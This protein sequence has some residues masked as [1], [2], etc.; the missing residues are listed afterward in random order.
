MMDEQQ[1]L[2]DT[3]VS[4]IKSVA[5]LCRGDRVQLENYE[6]TVF[7]LTAGE[8]GHFT[9]AA[10]GESLEIRVL[11][12]VSDYCE[13]EGRVGLIMSSLVMLGNPTRDL[14]SSLG[15]ILD[16]NCHRLWALYPKPRVE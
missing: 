3:F 1:V 14:T 10:A 4:K 13:G 6:D 2:L 15:Q 16:G 8:K 7:R 11:T 9:A 12:Q 5:A